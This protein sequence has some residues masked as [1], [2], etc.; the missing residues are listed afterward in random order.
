MNRLPVAKRALI[1]RL[2]CEGSSMRAASR[3]AEVSINTVTKLLV[4][5]GT[6]C[7]EFHDEFV[8]EVPSR[9]VQCDEIWAFCYAKR[10]NVEYAIAAPPEAGDVW[11]WTAIDQDSKL[12]ISWLVGGRDAMTALAFMNDVQLR[13]LSRVQMTTDGNTAYLDAVEQTFGADVD[14][15]QLVKLYGTPPVEEARRYSPAVCIGARKE[16]IVGDPDM[17]AVN[18]SYVERHNLTM[19]MSMRR[20]TRL[21]NAFSKKFENH[22]HMVA[23]YTAWYNYVRPH[24]TLKGET[25]AMASGLASEPLSME[26]L[27]ALAN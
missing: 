5:T 6:A 26:T 22:A 21:T 9:R 1:L 23:L 15:A 2:L 20:F 8:R 18:T 13:L 3:I 24:K 19:R 7:A 27:A 4:D 10:R 14:Y 11:T 25:P 12:V 16:A 17:D